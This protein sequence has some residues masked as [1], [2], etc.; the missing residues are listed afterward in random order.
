L[1][2]AGQGYPKFDQKKADEYFAK[3]TDKVAGLIS[4]VIRK[5]DMAG[6]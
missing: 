4:E 6:L 2:T 1:Y 5:W 3:V